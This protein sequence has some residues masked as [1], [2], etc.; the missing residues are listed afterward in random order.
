[1]TA[2]LSFAQQGGTGAGQ[3]TG[4]RPGQTGAGQTGAGQTGAGQTGAGKTGIGTGGQAGL[5]TQGSFGI[6][7][8]PWFSDPGIR[9]QLNLNDQQFNQ[10]NK[11]Y[12]QYF[13]KYQ[14]GYNQLGKLD[15]QQR[16]QR[17]L[18]LSGG[19]YNNFGQASRDVLNQDQ[20]QRFQQ[21]YLQYRGPAALMDPAIQDQLQLT[22]EQRQKLQRSGYFG[23]DYSSQA[24]A[25]NSANN[26]NNNN[27][28]NNPN[29][30]NNNNASNQNS[31]ASGQRFIQ[32]QQQWMRDFLTEEQRARWRE[33]TGTPYNFRPGLGTGSGTGS[34]TG[35]G[36]GTGTGASSTTPN[37]TTP[38][39]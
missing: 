17:M 39:P 10:L 5:G 15:D 22:P 2:T 28:N 19:F 36:T 31:Q 14:G 18:E 20:L 16:M 33:M 12:S 24:A 23:W 8:T 35:T 3:G 13:E 11:T 32:Q 34:G 21:L 30:N 38:R 26:N 7:Q 1:L 25:Q 6:T 9:K 27:N 37:S 29:N 4:A